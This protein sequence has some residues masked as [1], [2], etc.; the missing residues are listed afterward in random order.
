MKENDY[1]AMEQVHIDKESIWE[2]R[3]GGQWENQKNKSTLVEQTKSNRIK[4]WFWEKVQAMMGRGA[5][6][7][8]PLGFEQRHRES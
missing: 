7:E 2:N 5:L 3:C 4:S 1:R 6:T 8:E